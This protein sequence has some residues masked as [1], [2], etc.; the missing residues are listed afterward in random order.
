M[1]VRD[2]ICSRMFKFKLQ[3]AF[4]LLTDITNVWI[5]YD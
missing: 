5:L 4:F 3:L 2:K 1:S